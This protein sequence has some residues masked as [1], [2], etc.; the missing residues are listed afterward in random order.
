MID[1]TVA[2]DLGAVS[3][4]TICSQL[5]RRGVTG[6]FLTALR[7][8]NPG[9]RLLGEARTLRYTAFRSDVF[10]EVGGGMNAQKR[11][12]D[13]IEPGQVLVIEA[14]GQLAAGTIGDIL[15]LRVQ[16]RGG[17]GV[18]TDGASRDTP[19]LS[20]MDF[21]L[22]VGGAHGAVL[23]ERHVPMD[24]DLPITCAGVLVMPGDV[25]VGDAEGAVVIPRAMAADVGA[26]AREQELQETFIAERVA[27]G[28]PIAGL[29]PLGARWRTR[30]DQ[31]KESTT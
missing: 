14:R 21:P 9:Q 15:A 26:D 1:A 7:P 11:V 4:A 28:A 29:Y 27:E 8:L 30:Y 17:A 19:T 24:S 22:Y 2:A 18:V 5:R 10:D 25:V 3:T 12:V 23:G 20:A 13:S 6:T 16:Q 31:W